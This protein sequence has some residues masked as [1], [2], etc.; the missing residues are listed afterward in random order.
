[1]FWDCSV[2]HF[3]FEDVRVEKNPGFHNLFQLTQQRILNKTTSF[4]KKSSCKLLMYIT[5]KSLNSYYKYAL[6]SRAIEQRKTQTKRHM[7]SSADTFFLNNPLHTIQLWLRSTRNT[8]AVSR[9]QRR[10]ITTMSGNLRSIIAR[11][12]CCKTAP[13]DAILEDEHQIRVNEADEGAT[14]ENEIKI[15]RDVRQTKFQMTHSM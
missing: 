11:C 10:K 12:F 9:S 5:S 6:R 8:R 3:A 7:N 2:C 4:L 1:M 14:N 15:R 13:F